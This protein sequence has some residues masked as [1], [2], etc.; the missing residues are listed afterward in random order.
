MKKDMKK[1][2]KKDMKKDIQNL[3]KNYQLIINNNE[4]QN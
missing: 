4:I 3:K 2:K 1:E